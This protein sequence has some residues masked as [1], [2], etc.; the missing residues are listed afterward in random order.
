VTG[1]ELDEELGEVREQIEELEA[2]RR[3]RMEFL[4]LLVS[5]SVRLFGLAQ[6]GRVIVPP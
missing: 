3:R 2:Y 4:T 1:P 5:V 6:G